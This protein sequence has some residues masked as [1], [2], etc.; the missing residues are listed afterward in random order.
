MQGAMAIFILY[1]LRDESTTKAVMNYFEII[2]T[3]Y[4]TLHLSK[5]KKSREGM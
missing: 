4:K 5:T 2:F 1:M 3:Q